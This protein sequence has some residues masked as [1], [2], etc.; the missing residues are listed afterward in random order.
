MN[1][2]NEFK[3]IVKQSMSIV[4]FYQLLFSEL[5]LSANNTESKMCLENVQ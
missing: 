3:I 5:S 2:N 1:F 4:K